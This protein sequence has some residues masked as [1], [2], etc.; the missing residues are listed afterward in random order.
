MRET[1]NGIAGLL[2][3]MWMERRERPGGLFVDDSGGGLGQFVSASVVPC[4]GRYPCV[5]S[6]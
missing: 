2:S 6:D 3:Y 4:G 1:T 5:L